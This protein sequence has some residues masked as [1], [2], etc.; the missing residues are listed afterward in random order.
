MISSEKMTIFSKIGYF[1]GDWENNVVQESHET[2]VAQNQVP[3]GG[4]FYFFENCGIH[5]FCEF[6]K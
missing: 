1:G 6:Q 5:G 4:F 3:G 2:T